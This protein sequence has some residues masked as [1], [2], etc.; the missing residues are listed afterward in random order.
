[1]SNPVVWLQSLGLP[2]SIFISFES[3]LYKLPETSQI[4]AFILALGILLRET[5]ISVN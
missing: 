1:M 4:S 2:H 5:E 3:S